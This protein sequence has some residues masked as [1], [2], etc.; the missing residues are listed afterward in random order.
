MSETKPPLFSSSGKLHTDFLLK[1]VAEQRRVAQQKEDDLKNEARIGAAPVAGAMTSDAVGRGL[2]RDACYLIIS[3]QFGTWV[4]QYF[5]HEHSAVDLWSSLS[6]S[7]VSVLFEREVAASRVDGKAHTPWRATRTYGL[8]STVETIRAAGL[9]LDDDDDAHGGPANGAVVTV[10]AAYEQQSRQ[11]QAE[12]MGAVMEVPHI[13][14]PKGVRADFFF[15]F[16][17]AALSSRHDTQPLAG[18]RRLRLIFLFLKRKAESALSLSQ[19][20]LSLSLSLSLFSTL[21]AGGLAPLRSRHRGDLARRD[22]R[23]TSQ[24]RLRILVGF[25][26]DGSKTSVWARGYDRERAGK[27]RDARSSALELCDTSESRCLE[28]KPRCEFRERNAHDTVRRGSR[29]RT[30]SS[31][32]TPSPARPA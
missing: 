27:P 19:A 21:L 17:K 9:A 25:W 31:A 22:A 13:I 28:T 15:G 1:Q 18:V 11:K 4:S 6:Y 3:D 10:A 24:E 16:G 30:S 7:H 2:V 23:R 29:R 8:P 20:R 5:I 12:M 32:T 14:I 26:R